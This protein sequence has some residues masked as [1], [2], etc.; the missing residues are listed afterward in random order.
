MPKTTVANGPSLEDREPKRKIEQPVVV[1]PTDPEPDY[2][3]AGKP[4][5]LAKKRRFSSK[6]ASSARL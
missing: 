5:E 2:T 6:T 3:N 1:E 4:S